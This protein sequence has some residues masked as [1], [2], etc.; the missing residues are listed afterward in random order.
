MSQIAR[1]MSFS[2]IITWKNKKNLYLN[3]MPPAVEALGKMVI[4][5]VVKLQDR[6]GQC[7]NTYHVLY[8]DCLFPCVGVK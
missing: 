4:L 8:Q 2:W 3:H 1:I 5:G 7:T 6:S